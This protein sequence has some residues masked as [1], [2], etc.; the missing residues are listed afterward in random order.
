MNFFGHAWLASKQRSDPAYVFGAMLPDLAAMLRLRVERV[1]D[2]PLDAGRRF[3]LATD[4]AFHRIPAFERLV[5]GSTRALRETGL[6][7]GPAR[8]VGHVGI[9]LLLDGWIAERHGVPGPYRPALDRGPALLGAVVFR[10]RPDPAPLGDLCRRIAGAS[11][12]P[13]DWCAPEGLAARLVRILARRPR[14]ALVA[15]ELPA[16]RAWATGAR[17]SVAE[18]APALLDALEARLGAE[19]R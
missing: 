15:S 3:H 14:L 17:A 7:S 1:V 19:P 11:H 9:E 18:D 8:A 2:A 10:G 5:L 6:R 12:P 16:V 13:E 4:E